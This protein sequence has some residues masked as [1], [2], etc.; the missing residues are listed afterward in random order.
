MPLAK[1]AGSPMRA[2]SAGPPTS[3]SPGSERASPAG[4]TGLVV[5]LA[6]GGVGGELGLDGAQQPDLGGDLGGQAGEGNRG[7]AGVELAARRWAASSHWRARA[8]PWWPC[9]ALA[10]SAV[11]SA[12]RP[13]LTRA[14]GSA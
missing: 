8:A 11:S 9:E 4:S 13:S 1:R 14:R 5:A 2:T 3:A 10:I 12:S 7:V 6:F